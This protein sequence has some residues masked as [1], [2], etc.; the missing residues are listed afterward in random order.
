MVK[1]GGAAAIAAV[2]AASKP[3][4]E[5]LWA[6]ETEGQVLDSPERRAAL[7][8]RLRAHLA[9]I[10]DPSLRGHW[11]REIR[12]RR[13]ALFAPPPRPPRAADAG[14]PARPGR[15]AAPRRRA[16]RSPPRRPPPRGARSSPRSPTRPSRRR[17]SARARSSPAA[18]TIPGSPTTP[19]SASRRFTSAAADLAIVR[20]AL[21]SALSESLHEPHTRDSLGKAMHAR[22]G[23]RPAARPDDGW[24]RARQSP[25]RADGRDPKA[26]RRAIDEEIT[27]HAALAGRIEEVREAIDELAGERR[28]GA[29]RPPAPRRRGRSRRQYPPARRA[30]R[31]GRHGTQGFHQLLR[32]GRGPAGGPP[33]AKALNSGP[34]VI[35]NR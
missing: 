31:F 14:R 17:A 35:A 11:E 23:S 4:V 10:A 9:R 7:D 19:R 30:R 26:A 29:D 15:G 18:S 1:S 25:P 33:T 8:A 13:A 3:V 6:R 21:L 12:S 28:R 22:L 20:D 24:P 32:R 27:R 5:L 2:L 16:P 34:R